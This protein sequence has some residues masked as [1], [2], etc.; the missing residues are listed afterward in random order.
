[1]HIQQR[2][3]LM[4]QQKSTL[5]AWFK[6]I[7]AVKCDLNSKTNTSVCVVRSRT[8]PLAEEAVRFNA[9][10]E[11][12]TYFFGTRAKWNREHGRYIFF[13]ACVV[14]VDL[15]SYKKDKIPSVSDDLCWRDGCEKSCLSFLFFFFKFSKHMGE[16]RQNLLLETK[17]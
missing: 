5:S 11:E 12:V 17:L 13:S 15:F 16:K 9:A 14:S 10:W 8:A 6:P 1:M 7:A 2:C 4:C 3:R